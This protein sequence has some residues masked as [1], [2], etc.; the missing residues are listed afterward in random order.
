MNNLILIKSDYS[1]FTK[2]IHNQFTTILVY[3][4][5][6]ILPGTYAYEITS[7]KG[8]LDQKPTIKDIGHYDISWVL[9]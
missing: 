7:I 3:V 9:R 2:K 4:H 8:H 1:L 5:D 6:L